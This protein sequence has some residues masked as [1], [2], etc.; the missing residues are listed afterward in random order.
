MCASAVSHFLVSVGAAAMALGCRGPTPPR[1]DVGL[2]L[3]VDSVWIYRSPNEVRITVPVLVRNQDDRPLYVTPC[4]HALQ[5]ASGERWTTVWAS[6]CPPERFYSL[7][8]DPGESTVLS[9]G[10]RVS[11]E[12]GSWPANATAGT[13]RAIL[14]LTSLP[15]NSGGAGPA[16]PAPSS[17]TTE[18]FSVR[19]RTVVF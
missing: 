8:L 13:Y 18:P 2:E 9:L 17:R 14:H 19:V 6:Q 10:T 3:Q 12:S 1:Y 11:I 4:A 15:A 16:I 5:L 7:E